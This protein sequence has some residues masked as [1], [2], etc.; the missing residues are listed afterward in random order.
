MSGVVALV[1]RSVAPVRGASSPTRLRVWGAGLVAGAIVLLAVSTGALSRLSGQVDTIGGHDAP[2]A[3]TASDVYFEL[4]DLDAQVATLIMLGE[5]DAMS[6]NRLNALRTFRQRDVQVDIDLRQAERAATSVTERDRVRDLVRSLTIYRQWVWQALT[7]EDRL[8]PQAPGRPPSAA[9]G[10]YAEATT[11]L[12]ADL[13]PTAA[14]LRLANAD[15]LDRSYRAQHTTA[16]WAIGLTLLFGIALL[17]A[18]IVFQRQLT[19]GFRRLVNAP[20]ILATGCTLATMVTV[21][22]VF[23][24][25]TST[26][27]DAQDRDF[28]P[29]LALTQVQA[30]GYDAAGD[31]S[32]YLIAADPDLVRSDTVA[33]SGCLVKGGACGSGASLPAGGLTTLAAGTPALLEHWKAFQ[34]DDARMVAL[35]RAGQLDSAVD[36]LTGISPGDAAIDLFTYNKA[37]DQVTARHRDRY[38]RALSHARRLLTWWPVVPAVPLGAAVLLIVLGVRPRLAEYR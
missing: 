4:S 30:I 26:L 25:E 24:S 18:L 34:A 31:A 6:I 20:L 35:A 32:R 37:L 9:L 8:P 10:Y 19:R 29:Y 23:A 22:V 5:G 28:G 16:V 2:Q 14:A 21:C 1:H 33:K 27:R 11:V 3:A 36:V 17:V 13:L 15:D 38:A 12:R 7:V